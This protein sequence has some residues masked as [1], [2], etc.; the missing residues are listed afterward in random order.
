M[1][2]IA[3]FFACLQAKLVATQIFG[4]NLFVAWTTDTRLITYG[5]AQRRRETDRQTRNR[6]IIGP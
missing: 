6:K 5:T 1:L 2:V 4:T 3:F